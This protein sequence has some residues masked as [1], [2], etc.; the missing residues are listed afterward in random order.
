MAAP[1]CLP[2]RWALEVNILNEVQSPKSLAN[3]QTVAVV[4][5][6]VHH[7]YF[8]NATVISSHTSM[9]TIHSLDKMHSHN[10]TTIF[11]PTVSHQRS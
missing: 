8:K 11:F 1:V 9:Q 7:G 4:D 6:A 2:G 10:Q 5:E 3:V